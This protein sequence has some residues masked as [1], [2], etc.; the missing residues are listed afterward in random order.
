[1]EWTETIKRTIDYLEQHMLE[2][3]NV[4]ELGKVTAVSPFYLQKGF[5]LMTGVT[6]GEYIRNRRL[7]LAALDL[8]MRDEKVIDVAYHYGYE[9]PESFTRAFTRFH[10]VSPAAIKKE[11]SRINSY[12][13]LKISISILGGNAMDYVVEKMNAFK[14]VGFKKSIPFEHGYEKIPEFW[15]EF[16]ETYMQGRGPKENQEVV[17]NCM[18]GEYG[19]SINNPED[20]TYFDYLIAGMYDESKL[21]KDMVARLNEKVSEDMVIKEIPAMEWARFRCVGPL[22]GNL[23][24]LN[25]RIYTDWLPNNKEYD[26]TGDVTLEWYSCGDT[27]SSDYISEIWIPVKRK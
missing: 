23:Q 19:V 17:N 26:I 20:V 10:Q 2:Q 21:T 18:I 27:T 22:S 6:I 12:L 24:S 1:M 4:A 13:P 14:V 25:T 9:S 16:L 8:I 11:P 15:E 3:I 5:A 7:Y